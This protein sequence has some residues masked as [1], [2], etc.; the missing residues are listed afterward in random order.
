MELSAAI[1]TG[2]QNIGR[3]LYCKFIASCTKEVLTEIISIRSSEAFHDTDPPALT[4]SWYKNLDK[5]K[6]EL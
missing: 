1:D 6:Y 5:I 3:Y 2:E 4:V